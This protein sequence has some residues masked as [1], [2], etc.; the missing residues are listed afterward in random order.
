MK[1]NAD[2][3]ANKAKAKGFQI[4]LAHED[5]LFKVQIGAFSNRV[6]AEEMVKRAKEAGF[7]ASIIIN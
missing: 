2:Q 6:N 7:D 1:I 3:L 4:Y 5:T